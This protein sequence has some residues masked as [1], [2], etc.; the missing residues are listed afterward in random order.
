M[1]IHDALW[2]ESREEEAEQVRHFEK[3]DDHIGK[4]EGAVGYG[5]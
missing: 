4:I 1:T 3:N 5:T 2:V